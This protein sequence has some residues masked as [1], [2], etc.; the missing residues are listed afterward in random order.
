MRVRFSLLPWVLVLL[1]MPAVDAGA[2]APTLL[3][4]EVMASNASTIADD[5]G[6][7][8]DWVE[9]VNLTDAPSNLNGY[10]LTDNPSRPFKWVFGDVVIQPY[11]FLVVWASSKDRALHTS[12]AISA[13]G[14]TIVLTT[15][16]GT[17]LD[18]FATGSTSRAA[19]SSASRSTG[20]T[21]TSPPPSSSA[22]RRKTSR[23]ARATSG[24]GIAPDRRPWS[25]PP[26]ARQPACT[27]CR[28]CPRGRRTRTRPRHPAV[29]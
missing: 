10:G 27:A 19:A 9:I 25:R 13:G 12:W 8:S 24:R 14:E 26:A 16:D 29:P 3:L 21:S 22:T 6:D 20:P 23:A 1:V 15:P 2:Q 18:S 17:T 5:D 4:T 28:G 7:Y 11:Q